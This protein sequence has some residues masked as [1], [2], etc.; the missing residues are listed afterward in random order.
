MINSQVG[1]KDLVSGID[2]WWLGGYSTTHKA[3]NMNRKRI[4]ERS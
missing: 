2:K 4:Q 1:E 3:I